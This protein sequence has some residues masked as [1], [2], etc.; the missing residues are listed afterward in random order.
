[1]AKGSDRPDARA[2]AGLDNSGYTLW[3]VV[4]DGKQPRYSEGMLLTELVEVLQSLGPAKGRICLM[5]RFTIK[6]R[7]EHSVATSSGVLSGLP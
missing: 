3:L 1:M 2:A 5:P 6:G 4:V 7:W